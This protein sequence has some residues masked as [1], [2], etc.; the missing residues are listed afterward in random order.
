MNRTR[1]YLRLPYL[2]DTESLAHGVEAL[3]EAWRETHEHG[4][5]PADGVG[6][7]LDFGRAGQ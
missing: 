3:V 2:L 5:R 4:G 1:E 7:G 6:G